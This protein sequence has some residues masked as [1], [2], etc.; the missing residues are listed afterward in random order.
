MT[1]LHHA[2]DV[3]KYEYSALPEDGTMYIRLA[4]VLRSCNNDV[5][6]MIEH[7][8]LEA[9]PS[10]TA[11]SYLWGKPSRTYPIIANQKSLGVTKNL[12]IFFREAQRR[13]D[14]NDECS[15]TFHGWLWIDAVCINQDDQLERSQQV[16]HMKTIFEAAHDMIIWLGEGRGRTGEAL[17]VMREVAAYGLNNNERLDVRIIEDQPEHICELSGPRFTCRFPIPSLKVIDKNFHLGYWYR[18]WIFQEASTPKGTKTNRDANGSAATGTTWVCQRA[19]HI[20]FVQYL[21]ACRHL[22]WAFANKPKRFHRDIRG[23]TNGPLLTIQSFQHYRLECGYVDTIYNLLVETRDSEATD[24]RDKIYAIL[25]LASDTNDLDIKPDY[26]LST[27]EIFTQLAA[28]VIKSHQSLDCLGS[29]GIVKH[30]DIPSWAA[31][32]EQNYWR[33]PFPFHHRAR[34]LDTERFV[35]AKTRIYNASEGMVPN[36]DFDSSERK[37]LVSGFIFDTIREVKSSKGRR[38]SSDVEPAECWQEWISLVRQIGDV[39]VSSCSTFEAFA[40]LLKADVHA[41]YIDGSADRGSAFEE[42]TSLE[43]NAF[44]LNDFGT[45]NATAHRRLFATKNGYLGLAA[46]G[47][48]I[49]DS[50]CIVGGSQTPMVLR[51]VDDEWLFVGQAYIHGIMDGEAVVMNEG[52]PMR[53]FS[54][55]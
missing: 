24:A 54:M 53:P 13:L 9:A 28:R 17:D 22:S 52:K 10:F 23:V 12:L 55:R 27:A 44:T 18:S 30:K 8:P 45:H 6:I 25:G 39:Y 11:L 35:T 42:F 31:D 2:L 15:K 33:V 26:E 41:V 34:V 19:V 21:T 36:I 40:K 43:V 29:A 7:F 16:R 47:T 49:G 46:A 1:S 37:L 3:A 48:E 20:P 4:K 51:A 32:W 50:I 14:A 38:W 5:E